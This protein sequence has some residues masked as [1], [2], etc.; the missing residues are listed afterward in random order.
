MNHLRTLGKA[1]F[2]ILALSVITVGYQNCTNKVEGYITPSEP[3]I[4]SSETLPR[5]DLVENIPPSYPADQ[6]NLGDLRVYFDF[7]VIPSVLNG[8]LS[9]EEAEADCARNQNQHEYGN[10][11][12]KTL[13]TW[14]TQVILEKFNGEC[15]TTRSE[16]RRGSVSG[17][18]TQSGITRW[19]CLGSGGGTT[20]ICENLGTTAPTDSFA[21]Y[22]D[23]SSAPS[24][25]ASDI[26]EQ[27]ARTR[28]SGFETTYPGRRM[29]CTW[30]S[31]VLVD[32][33]AAAQCSTTLNVCRIG[34]FSALTETSETYRWTCT[35]MAGGATLS[36]DV[37]KAGSVP[38][39]TLRIYIGSNTAPVTSIPFISEAEA[40]SNCLAIANAS[41]ETLYKCTWG[42]AVLMDEAKGMLPPL[43]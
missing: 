16:C 26:T 18:S 37:Q 39:N 41:P 6:K 14:G 42:T 3:T 30:G 8:G 25:T 5:A 28:C 11:N 38:L 9:R 36:C 7:A 29:K 40:L 31:I 13:C 19:S 35:G 32:K 15:S 20:A 43:L 33:A 12:G 22:L 1:F 17:L 21:F 2:Y 34:I 27:S 4:E 23:W 10:P 24:S